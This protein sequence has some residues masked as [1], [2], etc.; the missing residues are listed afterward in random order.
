MARVLVVD[1]EPEIG[2]V[3]R[4]ILTRAGFDVVVA[5]T[6]EQGESAA[7]TSP[8]DVVITDVIM[9]KTHGIDLIRTLKARFAGIRIVAISGG[10]NFG[11]LAYQPD[12]ISTEAYLE[13]ARRAGAE[14]VLTKPFDMDELLA[15]VRRLLPN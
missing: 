5:L 14:E 4:R 13:S 12:A 15:T 9:P 11:P 2:E 7:E 6:A 8:F 1:D 3:I 10:G